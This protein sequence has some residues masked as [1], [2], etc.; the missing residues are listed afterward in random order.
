MKLK[1]LKK[2]M[3]NKIDI[4]EKLNMLDEILKQMKD[5]NTSLDENIE[6]Y[7]KGNLL[8]LEI[9]KEIS[10]IDNNIGKVIE[11]DK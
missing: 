2:P 10:E 5:P 1:E 6:L 8:V 11:I 3:E 7:K 4:K 9:E